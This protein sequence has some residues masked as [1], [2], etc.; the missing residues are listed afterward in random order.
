MVNL[1]QSEAEIVEIIL[2]A[3]AKGKSRQT[4]FASTVILNYSFQKTCKHR[5]L[6]ALLLIY[7]VGADLHES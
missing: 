3:S 5:A 6:T 7:V 4:N 1:S 2:R